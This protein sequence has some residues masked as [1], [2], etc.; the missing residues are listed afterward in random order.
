M[1]RRRLASRVLLISASGRVLLFKIR[2]QTGVLAGMSYWATPG[3]QLR[4]NESFETAAIRE[5]NEETGIE[6][7]SVGQCISHKE[8]PWKMPDGEEV[9]AVENYYI[10]RVSTERH[11]HAAWSGQERDAFVDVRWWSPAELAQCDELIYPPD[12]LSLFV[13]AVCAH[14]SKR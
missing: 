6:L 7:K 5:L 4:E 14:A 1:P 9:I 11:S 13:E 3:G 10:V 2:Y 12:L 8:F